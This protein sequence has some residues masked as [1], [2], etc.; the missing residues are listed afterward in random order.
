[1]SS[2]WGENLKMSIF[3]ESHGTA[4]GVVIDGLPAGIAL[5][6][7]K[8]DAEM[9]RRR[10]GQ[11]IYTTQRNETDRV[12]IV[13]GF[14]NGFTTGTP[15]CGII[16]NKDKR[17][18][19]YDDIKNIMRPGHADYT[20]FVR[21]NGFSD[22]RGGGHFSGRLTAPI[23]FAGAIANQYLEQRGIVIGTHL[24]QIGNI[25]DKPMDAVNITAGQLQLFRNMSFPV[26]CDGVQDKM[27]EEINAARMDRDSVGGILE[28]GIINLPAGIGTPMF[29]S[30]ESK[31]SAFIFSIPGVKGIEFGTGFKLASMRGSEAN[32]EFYIS[33]E[34]AE[35]SNKDTSC[36]N[37][38]RKETPNNTLE[39]NIP[40][41]K[42]NHS[43]GINGGITNGMPVLFRTCIKPTSTIS[44]PQHTVNIATMDETEH[45]FKGRHDPC[46][47]VRAV[48]VINAAATL[49][50]M[51]L[52][53]D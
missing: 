50:I 9:Q 5:D 42:T 37:V 11:S 46:I 20:G 21:Y 23:V 47:A 44:K 49:V 8:I 15:L 25:Q 10:P 4:I 24:L 32:D 2:T 16:K 45:T 40:M 13:S 43:G 17:S 7:R 51:D 29:D 26:V 53:L 22:Y 30:V 35:D 41:T 19:D 38:N 48:P 3:G 6:I 1:M 14:F 36:L 34:K 52:L 27:K 31:L 33:R 39:K 18:N 28:T 12:E